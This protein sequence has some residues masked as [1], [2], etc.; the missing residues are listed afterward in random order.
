MMELFSPYN[1]DCALRYQEIFVNKEVRTPEMI[2]WKP[3][4]WVQRWTAH[5]GLDQLRDK[6]KYTWDDGLLYS[7][8][9]REGSPESLLRSFMGYKR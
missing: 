6:I 3:P 4:D 1:L 9:R 5:F 2:N 8:K 7:K